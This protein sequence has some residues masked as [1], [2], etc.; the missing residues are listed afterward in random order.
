MRGGG[1]GGDGGG[2]G[3]GF[4]VLGL[5]RDREGGVTLHFHAGWWSLVMVVVCT[6]GGVAG[7][8][9]GHYGSYLG[10]SW[11]VNIGCGT[12]LPPVVSCVL[13]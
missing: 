5:G 6:L 1:G 9:G 12:R 8:R 10:E 2:G 7:S 3:E 4:R 11:V 13:T